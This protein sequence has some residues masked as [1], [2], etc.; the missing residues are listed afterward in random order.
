ML[1][2]LMKE[3]CLFD[4]RNTCLE[5]REKK[6]QR[7]GKARTRTLTHTRTHTHTHAH[8]HAHAHAHSCYL[9]WSRLCSMSF[10]KKEHGKTAGK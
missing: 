10:G 4:L 5:Y 1:W 3:G 8:A 9:M 7:Q 2:F 6:K